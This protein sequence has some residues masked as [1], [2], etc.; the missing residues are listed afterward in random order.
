MSAVRLSAS[1]WIEED[2][3]AVA[4]IDGRLDPEDMAR[5]LVGFRGPPIRVTQT[6]RYVRASSD[7]SATAYVFDADTGMV[8]I[9]D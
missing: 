3:P 9:L 8:Y 1:Q 7:G 6:M 4:V 5:A 2:R